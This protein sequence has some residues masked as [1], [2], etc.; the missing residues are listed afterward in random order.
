[1]PSV[2]FKLPAQELREGLDRIREELRV[3]VRF[4]PELEDEAER[5]RVGHFGRE[6]VALRGEGGERNELRARDVAFGVRRLVPDVQHDQP[7]VIEMVGKPLGGYQKRRVLARRGPLRGER[8]GDPED[9]DCDPR[10]T[11]HGSSARWSVPEPYGSI[12]AGACRIGFVPL[13]SL[14]GCRRTPAA[15]RDTWLS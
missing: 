4:P 3:P 11:S 10:G 14:L 6:P 12:G 5:A 9:G 13:H 7:V 2:R 8:S 1:M 15:V